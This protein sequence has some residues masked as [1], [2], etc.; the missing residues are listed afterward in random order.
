M[1]GGLCGRQPGTGSLLCKTNFPVLL[2]LFE[3][4]QPFQEEEE[5][6]A[7]QGPVQNLHCFDHVAETV[8]HAMVDHFLYVRCFR[9][10]PRLTASGALHISPFPMFLIA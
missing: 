4:N 5:R 7:A 3:K 1:M 8:T 10:T 6:R 2:K 9:S